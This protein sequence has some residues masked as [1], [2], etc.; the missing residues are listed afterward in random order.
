MNE[1]RA[2]LIETAL[3]LFYQKGINSV[4][5]NEVLKTSAVAKKTLYHHFSGKEELVLATLQRRNDIFLQWLD[6]QLST[7][8]NDRE[9]VEVLFHALS[10][11]LNDQVAELAIFRG[12][13]FINTVAEY[14]DGTSTIVQY[15]VEHKQR[16]RAMIAARLQNDNPNLLDLI[17][18]LKE[19]AIVSA[20]TCQDK[21]AAE[22]SLAVVI[23]SGYL[24]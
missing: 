1:K 15:C 17:C 14:P 21:Q 2:L 20:Q 10:R 24:D 6:E 22:K 18:L 3:D 16:V 8:E 23:Q 5:I 13:F 19:G 11:W 9:L 12:C 7:A 4:G